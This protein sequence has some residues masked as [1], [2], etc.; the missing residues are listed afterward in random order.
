MR[1]CA[2]R[3]GIAD[4]H[5]LIRAGFRRYLSTVDDLKIVGEASNAVDVFE[6][7]QTQALDVLLLDVNMPPGRTGIEIL[8]ELLA[9]APALR[10]IVMSA[11]P[12]GPTAK[13]ALRAGAT[14]Y[15]E[16]AEGPASVVHVLRAAAA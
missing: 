11:D 16:K 7:V 2:I 1:Q 10:V 5:D 9:I 13:A 12:P 3:V 14:A 8:P 15:L 6:L 4:D